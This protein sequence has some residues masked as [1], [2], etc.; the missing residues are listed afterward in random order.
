MAKG[1]AVVNV[2]RRLLH[3]RAVDW[4]ELR[5]SARRRPGPRRPV[6]VEEL[7]EAA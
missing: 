5:R 4:R 2:A 7:E 3:D 6:N 1:H